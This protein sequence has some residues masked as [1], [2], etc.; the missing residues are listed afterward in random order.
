MNKNNKKISIVVPVL[1]EEEVIDEFYRRL[2]TVLEDQ[3]L[4]LEIIFVDDGSTDGS[5]SKIKA[6]RQKDERVNIISFSR[7]FGHSAAIT[8]GLENSTGDAVAVMDSDLQDPPE[9]LIKFINEWRGGTQVVYGIRTK[10]KEN[11]LKRLSYWFFYRI[12]AGTSKTEI[13][14]DAGDFCLMDRMVIDTINS[15]PERNRFVRG[16]RSWAGFRQAGIEFERAYRYAGKTK[17][18]FRKLLGLAGDGIFSFS[19]AP[20]RAVT[21]LGFIIAGLTF[22]AIL[23]V[24]YLRIFTGTLPLSG[25]SS[26]IIVVL[27]LGGMQ[28]I[29]IGVVGEYIARIYEET[30]N[31][32]LYIIKEKVG[33][34]K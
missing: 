25:F 16:L 26:I 24:L 8:A 4:D 14:L 15:M 3:S 29:A 10:R 6:L 12:L 11:I 9:M 30:K 22:V 33:L 32:P 21:I 34:Q 17:Y 27:F 20:L 28:L 5:L 2:V 7:N 23:I 18:P 1:N 19:Y 13:P 31:R